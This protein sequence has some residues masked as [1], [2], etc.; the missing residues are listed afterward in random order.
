MQFITSK[1]TRGLMA[2]VM[3]MHRKAVLSECE[4]ADKAADVAY[5]AVQRQELLIVAEKQR[6]EAMRLDATIA[7]QRADKAWAEFAEEFGDAE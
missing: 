7:E 1:L 4:A 5:N 6:L 2:A 3:N